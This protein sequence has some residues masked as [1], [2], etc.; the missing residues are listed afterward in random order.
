[1]KFRCKTK[2][3]QKG[4]QLVEKA[5]SSR[6]SLPVLENV[7]LELSDRSL[8]MRG[9]DL[10]IGIETSVDVESVERTGSVLVKAKTLS[11]IM[12]KITDPFIDIE[13]DSNAKFILKSAKLDFD[14]L[15]MSSEDYPVFPSLESGEC[16]SIKVSDLI[17]L[18]KYTIFSVSFDE[19]KQFLNGIHI[20]NEGNKLVFVATDGYRLALKTL[21]F[22]VLDGQ[23]SIIAPFKAMHELLKMLQSEAEDSD[24]IMSISNHQISF[25]LNS[26]L[27]ISR[28][29]QG[30]FP[31]YN[32]VIPQTCDFSYR[33]SSSELA[34]ASERASIISSASNNVVRFSFHDTS[35]HIAAQAPG[36]GEFKE[37]IDLQKKSGE[38][39]KTIA[40]NIR[41]VLDVLKIIDVEQL[42]ISFNSELSPCRFESGMDSSYLFIV[43]PIRTSDFQT[44]VSPAAASVSA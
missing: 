9:N 27:L 15:G 30:Q 10:E 36:V 42:S 38:G 2:N 19:T 28:V 20:K 5:V 16:I 12:S 41:L 13:V 8:R 24:V 40:F 18:I 25:T 4:I 17:P 29:I 34:S 6:S 33:V 22:P 32:R 26:F 37:D 31:D 35:L 11:S 23:F 21:E 44:P 43:M 1:M 7:Y 3:F 39:V 14:I